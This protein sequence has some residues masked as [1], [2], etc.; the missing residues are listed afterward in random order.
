MPEHVGLAL[1][2]GWRV[3]LLGLAGVVAFYHGL[4]TLIWCDGEWWQEAR[5]LATGRRVRWRAR[6][7]PP[8]ETMAEARKVGTA[9]IWENHD[10]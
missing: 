4:L 7:L 1:P 6:G 2:E 5:G 8:A 10:D 3:E 9:W